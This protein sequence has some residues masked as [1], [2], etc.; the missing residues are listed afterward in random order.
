MM[1]GGVG[2]QAG[3]DEARAKQIR[4][5]RQAAQESRP[6][7]AAQLEDLKALHDGGLLS[8]EEL[9]AAKRIV[10]GD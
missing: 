3:L 5:E 7:V 6:D 1:L 8:P 10:L 4:A 9:Q 2:F